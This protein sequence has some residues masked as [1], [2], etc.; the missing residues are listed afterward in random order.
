MSKL[1][2]LSFNLPVRPVAP[3]Q[4]AEEAFVAAGSSAARRAKRTPLRND[5]AGERVQVYLDP[6]LAGRMR[7]AAASTRRSQSDLVAAAVELYLSSG[8]EAQR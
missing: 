3:P 4:P 8:G 7:V 6:D 5:K 1:K 2:A